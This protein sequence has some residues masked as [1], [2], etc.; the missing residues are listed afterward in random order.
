MAQKEDQA[1]VVRHILNEQRIITISL[2]DG[3]PTTTQ[4]AILSLLKDKQKAGKLVQ[5]SFLGALQK[6]KP[7]MA[8]SSRY[9]TNLT[10]DTPTI[11]LKD[12][13]PNDESSTAADYVDSIIKIIDHFRR[14]LTLEINAK[15]EPEMAEAVRDARQTISTLEEEFQKTNDFETSLLLEELTRAAP[16]L[17][18]QYEKIFLSSARRT[19]F[20]G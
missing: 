15:M 3:F 20:V 16:L 18:P 14:P 6:K 9:Q 7:D 1:E 8:I 10:L 19:F 11:F 5:I 13:F 17:G 2:T 4:S 12:H